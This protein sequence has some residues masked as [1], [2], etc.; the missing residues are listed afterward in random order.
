MKKQLTKLFRIVM[1]LTFV[2]AM[3][4]ALPRPVQAASQWFEIISVQADQSVKIR[5]HSFPA[6]QIFTVRMDV[7]GNQA[8]NGIVVAETN[9][10]A[11]GD[12]EETYKI[13]AELKGVKTITIRMDSASGLYSYNWFNNASATS[14][15]TPT[16]PVIPATGPTYVAP[17]LTITAVDANHQATVKV[18]GFPAWQYFTVRVGPFWTFSSSYV[19]AETVYSGSGGTFSFNIDIPSSVK[20][21]EWVAVRL[22]SPQKYYAY[23]AFKNVDLGTVSDNP[24][25]SIITND[26]EIVSTAPAASVTKGVDFDAVWTVKNLSGKTWDMNTVDYKYVSGKDMYKFDEAYDLT[27]SVKDDG[28]IKITVDMIAPNTTGNFTTKWAL[29]QGKT[30]LCELP[31]TITVK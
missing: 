20:D 27:K 22:D 24:G 14:P 23:N 8:L 18:T 7:S 9:T 12:F 16:N 1:A 5:A 11:G 6:N 29:V 2:A 15:T 26:C 21:G 28:E 13:P 10:G 25:G 3:V 31:L 4:A 19:V 30:T 17:N